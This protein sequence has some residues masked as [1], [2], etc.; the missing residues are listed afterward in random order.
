MSDNLRAWVNHSGPACHLTLIPIGT[1]LGDSRYGV[2]LPGAAL[3]T[4]WLA[5]GDI[6]HTHIVAEHECQIFKLG[7]DNRYYLGEF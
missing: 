5:C 3:A 2:P 4:S 1:G 7:R 6:F